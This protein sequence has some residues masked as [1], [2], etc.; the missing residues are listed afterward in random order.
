MRRAFLKTIRLCGIVLVLT[1]AAPAGEAAPGRA[2]LAPSGAQVAV[3]VA[4]KVTSEADR[5][6]LVLTLSREIEARAFLMERPDRVI[7]ELAEVNFHLPPEAGRRGDGLIAAFRYGLFAPGRSRVVIDLAQPAVV[8]R[9]EATSA[10]DGLAVLRV[11]LTRADRETFRKGLATIDWEPDV[12]GALPGPPPPDRRPLIVL[13]PGHGGI[14]PGA[15]AGGG[16]HEKDIVFGFAERLR[17]RL[18]RSGRY[19]VRLTRERDLFVP[20]DERV[21][22]ARDVQ[23]DL[24]ISIHADSISAAPHVRGLTVYTGSEQ[25]SD[26]ESQ[27]LAERENKADAAAGLDIEGAPGDVA[28]ILYDLTLRETRSFS[29][30][31]AHRLVAAVDPV[32]PLSKKPQRQ[33]AFRVL[34][35]PDVPSVLVELGYLSSQK[36]IDLLLSEAWRDRSAHAMAAAID[37]F[38]AA[39]VAGRH[40]AP[41]SP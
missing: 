7:V 21:R 16:A 27:R 22:L 39:R 35:A 18:E 37:G 19:R 13:D 33:A 11:E 38:F 29:Q 26:T 34:R 5:T 15:I 40:A 24:F 6:Q 32:M 17:H 23:A 25:A 4:A 2:P 31:F 8:S 36:D 12:T 20:L 9:L 3:A 14:D 1:A 10:A 41:V 30:R 28:D